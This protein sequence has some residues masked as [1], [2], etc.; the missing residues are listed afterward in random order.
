MIW[1]TF[2]KDIQFCTVTDQK[3]PG[4]FVVILIIKCEIK[5]DALF[6]NILFTKYMNDFYNLFIS[7]IT[8]FT[9]S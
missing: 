5:N 8:I 2:L 1:F 4:D 9:I 3:N 7:Q 6:E